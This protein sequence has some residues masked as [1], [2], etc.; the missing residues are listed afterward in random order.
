MSK[1]RT[2]PIAS[3]VHPAQRKILEDKSTRFRAFVGGIGSGKSYCGCL[4]LIQTPARRSLVIAPTYPML[5]DGIL[6]L[7][8][9]MFRPLVRKH[10]KANLT[11][12]LVDGRQILWRPADVGNLDRLRGINAGYLLAD[13]GASLSRKAWNVAIGRIRRAP[14]RALVTTTPRGRDNWVH[15]VFVKE[16]S[17]ETALVQC[18]SR[19]NVWLPDGWIDSVRAQ[20][21]SR[22]AEQEIEGLF[23]SLEQTGLFDRD[24]FHIATSSTP[25]QSARVRFWDL[26]STDSK[27]SDYSSSC[28]VSR[29]GDRLWFDVRRYKLAWLRPGKGGLSL[30]ERIIQTALEDGPEVPLALETVAGFRI[31]FEEVRDDK[32][33]F[34]YDVRAISP[35]KTKVSRAVPVAAKAEQGKASLVQNEDTADLLRELDDFPQKNK[36]NDMVD[37]MSGALS[38]LDNRGQGLQTDNLKR[39]APDFERFRGGHQ[40]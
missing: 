7:F 9:E 19:D 18:S 16:A 11:T 8:L 5:K 25:A 26:A 37:A 28:L 31:A 13:E 2:I 30:K 32:R 35:C 22:F 4:D 20:Y 23:V 17:P 6:S 40:W 10:N 14:G 36:K 3:R 24:W 15:D 29:V 21:T 12:Q 27:R 33:L 1:K 34:G 39:P 38:V